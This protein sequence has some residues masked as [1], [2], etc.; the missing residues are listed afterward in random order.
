MGTTHELTWGSLSVLRDGR[1]NS[2]PIVRLHAYTASEQAR[3]IELDKAEL[4][5]L[6][7]DASS[8]L[9]IL[10]HHEKRRLAADSAELLRRSDWERR[11]PS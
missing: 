2:R 9:S 5:Q 6:L 4:V 8:A 3:V 11:Q 10:E 1:Q 7:V